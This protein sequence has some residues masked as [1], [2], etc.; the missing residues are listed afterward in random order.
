MSRVA[1][2]G[3]PSRLLSIAILYD[4]LAFNRFLN[5]WKDTLDV[6]FDQFFG[7]FSRC[8]WS[9]KAMIITILFFAFVAAVVAGILLDSLGDELRQFFFGLVDSWR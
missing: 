5:S 2:V 3:Q 7:S 4:S 6:F 8:V 9:F 1:T